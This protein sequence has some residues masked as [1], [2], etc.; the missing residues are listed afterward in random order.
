MT[1]STMVFQI[2]SSMISDRIMG[3]EQEPSGRLG[4]RRFEQT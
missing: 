4:R 3:S 2:R 1:R